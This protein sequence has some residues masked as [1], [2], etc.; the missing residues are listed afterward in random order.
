MLNTRLK[1]IRTVFGLTQDKFAKQIHKSNAYICRI[2]SG[3]VN[4][5]DDIIDAICEVYHIN[6]EWL[7]TGTGDMFEPGFEG[8][9]IDIEG[10]RHRVRMIRKNEKLTQDEFAKEIGYSKSHVHSVE[11]GMARPSNEFLQ[12][13]TNRYGVN[14]DWL[15]TGVGEQKPDGS[16]EVDD[17]LIEWL[18][19]HPE[20]VKELRIRGGLD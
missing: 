5:P 16:E 8:D 15:L 17:K 4:P 19:H 2:E 18:R 7:R 9:E 10:T 1:R 13:I 20:V 6:A 14:Y 3:K 11:S 12:K